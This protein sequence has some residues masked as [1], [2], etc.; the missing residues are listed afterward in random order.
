[1]KPFFH[2]TFFI[3][4]FTLA[5]CALS[6]Q[7]ASGPTVVRGRVYDTTSGKYLLNAQVSIVGAGLSAITDDLGEYIIVGAPAGK[8]TVR[9]TYGDLSP[10]EHAI[11][12]AEGAT[13]EQNFDLEAGDGIVKL[14]P[15][16]VQAR[17]ELDGT[18]IALNEQ[19]HAIIS[20]EVLSSEELGVVPEG[21]IGEFLKNLPGVNVD[22]DD[23]EARTISIRGLPSSTVDV[24]MDGLAAASAASG[25]TTRAFV[26]EQVSINNI[27]RI[28]VTKSRT[29]DMPANAM[30]GS[31]NLV[32]KSAF[33]RREA[34]TTLRTFINAT[35][36]G[37]F[38]SGDQPFG[39]DGNYKRHVRPGFDFTHTNPLTKN[40]GF[41]LTGLSSSQYNHLTR[42]DRSW[43]PATF[44]VTTSRPTPDFVTGLNPYF[45]RFRMQSTPSISDR[46]SVGLT[47]DWRATRQDVFSLRLQYNK[48]ESNTYRH[49]LVFDT[50]GLSTGATQDDFSPTFTN[51]GPNGSVSN[52][53]EYQNKKGSTWTSSLGYRHNGPAW[54]IDAGL[55][56]SQ[57]TNHF[58]D[59]DKGYFGFATTG[60]RNV[61]VGFSDITGGLPKTITLEKGGAK[62]PFFD[63]T[64]PQ[65][66][67][68]ATGA[69]TD[70]A[71]YNAPLASMQRD[72]I[73]MAEHATVNARRSFRGK[74]PFT[75]QFGADV[76][77]N[78]RD[79]T[80]DYRV[81]NFYGPPDFNANNQFAAQY[82]NH[83]YSTVPFPFG[84]GQVQWLDP[85]KIYDVYA[86]N[87]EWFPDVPRG[88]YGTHRLNVENSKYIQETISA[89]YLRG[90]LKLMHGRLWLVGGVRYERT[91]DDA[92]GSLNDPYAI[93]KKNPETGESWHPVLLDEIQEILDLYGPNSENYLNARNELLYQK[94]AA[95]ARRHYDGLYPSLNASFLIL[96]GLVLRAGYT[97]SIARPDLEY[98]IPGTVM[99]MPGDDYDED[100]EMIITVNNTG[101]KPWQ[102]DAFDL[103]LE[104]YFQKSS[105]IGVSVFYKDIKDFF[106]LITTP[107]TPG[108]LELYGFEPGMFDNYQGTPYLRFHFNTDRL[109]ARG[110]EFN[111]RQN[112]TFLPSWARGVSVYANGTWLGLSGDRFADFSRFVPRTL[113][114][115]ISLNRPRY[116]IM[117]KWI[118]TAEQ[119]RTVYASTEENRILPGTY[120]YLA[121]S[122][123]LDITAE[124]R[125]TK[126]VSFYGAARNVTNKPYV[127]KRY[128]PE[129]PE[130]ARTY[131]VQDYGAQ[132]ILG[133][134]AVF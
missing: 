14:D 79:W 10:K 77:R 113:N 84:V 93:Y 32:S 123:K 108:L 76:R 103:S 18:L 75:L 41:V 44:G 88:R 17:Q 6:A 52:W 53:S 61:Q 51:G 105:R 80:S 73:N 134:K 36:N 48:F 129:T 91:D 82:I 90:D 126:N 58:R 78:T 127:M 46:Q 95:R 101:L 5:L 31:V 83:S 85:K 86:G 47:L 56:I 112:L 4:H 104:Y 89:L 100:G 68:Q 33:E 119:R 8:A 117:L 35:S 27:A 12:L 57:S 74:I 59:R 20:K 7:T 121:G 50:G 92:I 24:T 38:D 115:G 70:Y 118:N 124:L 30:G 110:F 34:S 65:F 102:A 130:Y 23:N 97:R 64:D 72:S 54:K 69:S 55:T 9:A 114:W 122:T 2:Y 15:Y 39:P 94:R 125:L 3:L 107:A 111:Y 87:P 42:N 81:Y 66:L 11:T 45:H 99:A 98:I 29:P 62:V 37:E 131:Y 96:D 13:T 116:S 40:F 71:G 49:V 26:F 133:V 132:F 22:Y 21:N 67:L 109:I 63:L 128:A 19:R 25:N 43:V 60:I 16:V 1:M 120:Q 28:E 106:G